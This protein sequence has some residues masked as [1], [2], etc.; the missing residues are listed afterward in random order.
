MTVTGPTLAT[1]L[2]KAEQR[3]REA[4]EALQAASAAR[5]VRV[6]PPTVRQPRPGPSLTL[7]TRSGT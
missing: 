2:A 6:S 4:Y 7:R 5:M 1:Q 3:E